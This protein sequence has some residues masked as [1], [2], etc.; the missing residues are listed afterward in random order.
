M[1]F[2]IEQ[3]EPGDPFSDNPSRRIKFS[4]LMESRYI[5]EAYRNVTTRT[6]SRELKRLSEMYFIKFGKRGEA[7]DLVVELDFRAIG[8]Y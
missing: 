2:L 6:F 5:R 1:S 8:K 4:E 7:D 3:T